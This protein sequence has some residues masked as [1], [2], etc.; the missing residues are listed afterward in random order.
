MNSDDWQA[1][2][3]I[4]CRTLALLS[5]VAV[6]PEG[7]A[8]ML[9]S[10]AS[11]LAGVLPE[12]HAKLDNKSPERWERVGDSSASDALAS[13]VGRAIS[14]GEWLAG[15]RLDCPP[16]DWYCVNER[17]ETVVRALQLLAARGELA[18]RYGA[19]YVEVV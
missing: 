14:D 13:R 9:R 6:L 19:Y 1:L 16:G 18:V 10:Y 15:E 17:R 8:V 12:D 5:H 3:D 7:L 2:R 4:N 11:E